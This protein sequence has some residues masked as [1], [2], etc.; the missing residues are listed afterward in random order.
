[1]FVTPGCTE[2]ASPSVT[3]T[4]PTPLG[5]LSVRTNKSCILIEPFAFLVGTTEVSVLLNQSTLACSPFEFAETRPEAP[6]TSR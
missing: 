5:A 1:M 2:A 4:A 3:I 6:S